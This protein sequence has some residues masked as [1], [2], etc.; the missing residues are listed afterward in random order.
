MK[1]IPNDL[2]LEILSYIAVD[3]HSCLKKI[4]PLTDNIII[5]CKKFYFCSQEC[6][7]FI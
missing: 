4:N 5:I 6:Y 3:C 1:S 7:N 2:Q